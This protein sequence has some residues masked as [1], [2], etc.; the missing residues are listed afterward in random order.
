MNE[1][2][3]RWNSFY[4]DIMQTDSTKKGFKMYTNLGTDLR[5]I[6]WDQCPSPL[7][8]CHGEPCDQ[9]W[10]LGQFWPIKAQKRGG[11]P[12]INQQD[13]YLFLFPC[14]W[15]CNHDYAHNNTRHIHNELQCIMILS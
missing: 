13:S 15:V 7:S 4:K 10:A 9:S 12:I 2:L 1:W 5:T 11:W 6:K 8:N 3:M 14:Q